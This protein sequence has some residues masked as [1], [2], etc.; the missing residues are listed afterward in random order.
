MGSEASDQMIALLQELSQLKKLDGENQ[1]TADE[2]D[3]EARRLRQRRHEEITQEM[4]ALAEKK[5]D[6]R[7]K[8]P[9]QP[10]K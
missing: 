7:T 2:S 4:K 5:A 8:S 6:E 9:T 1:V 3:P 10:E